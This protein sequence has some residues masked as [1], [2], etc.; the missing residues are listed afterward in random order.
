MRMKIYASIPYSSPLQ[1][2]QLLQTSYSSYT[3][4]HDVHQDKVTANGAN[5]HWSAANDLAEDNLV[6]VGTFKGSAQ[7]F[8]AALRQF[9]QAMDDQQMVYLLEYEVPTTY[10]YAS[11]YLE[12]PDYSLRVKERVS[13]IA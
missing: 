6:V 2:Y 11:H 5:W 10:G 7:D 9:K 12:H 4:A 3:A 1:F 13:V 8:E